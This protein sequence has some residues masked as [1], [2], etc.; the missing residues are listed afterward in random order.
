VETWTTPLDLVNERT[1]S[2]CP[3]SDPLFTTREK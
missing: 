3:V 1:R 2:E